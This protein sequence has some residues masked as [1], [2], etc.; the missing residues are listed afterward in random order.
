MNESGLITGQFPVKVPG[1]QAESATHSQL[2]NR[3]HGGLGGFKV[4]QVRA[5]ATGS[6]TFSVLSLH[7]RKFQHPVVI[8]NLGREV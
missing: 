4:L 7:T 1:Y 3:L 5:I 2:K 6:P 8:K